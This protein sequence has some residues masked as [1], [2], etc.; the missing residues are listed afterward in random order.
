MIND[1]FISFLEVEK[2]FSGHT[3]RAYSDDLHQFVVF[4]EITKDSDWK[5]VNHQLIRGWIVALIESGSSN[6]TVARKLSCLR[7]FFK[8]AI[9][10]GYV[11][12]NPMLRVKAP[13]VE[14]RLPNFVKES[15]LERADTVK[16][17]SDNFDGQRDQLMVEL[18]YQTGVRLSELI[19]LKESDVHEQYIKVLGKRNKERIIP[20]GTELY[21]LVQK[22]R[23]IKPKENDSREFLFVKNDGRKLSAKF[24]Y[25]KINAYLGSVSSVQRKSP[26][27]L[28][29]TFATHL[30]NNG[31]GLETLKEL[32]GHAGLSA[33]QV[34]THNSFAQISSIYSHAHPR[35]RKK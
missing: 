6:R 33:T 2:R 18:F 23:Y 25:R 22:Y 34:Y 8:W 10:E 29:H 27:V 12:E 19:N 21:G 28:R 11:S 30:L 20:I 9:H 13:K 16:L 15:E 24:V 5:D 4:A 17:F 1:A 31:A 32:L 26:H 7:S 14:K 35:G 3:L